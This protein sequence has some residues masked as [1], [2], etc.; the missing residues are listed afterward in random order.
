MK[1]VD[2]RYSGHRSVKRDK[3]ESKECNLCGGERDGNSS[4]QRS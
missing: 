1:K 2:V 3:M 4:R